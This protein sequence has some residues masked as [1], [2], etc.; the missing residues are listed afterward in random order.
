MLHALSTRETL[1]GQQ[2]VSVTTLRTR[3]D[4]TGG[5]VAECCQTEFIQCG[6]RLL[7]SESGQS[8]ICPMKLLMFST[9]RQLLGPQALGNSMLSMVALQ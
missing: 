2:R 5:M 3:F 7:I 6:R 1:H 9:L 8:P 4:M